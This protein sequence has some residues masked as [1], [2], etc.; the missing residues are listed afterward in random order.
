MSASRFPQDRVR[1]LSKTK[2]QCC[3]IRLRAERKA[4]QILAK[5]RKASGRPRKK[6]PRWGKYQ[7]RRPQKQAASLSGRLRT[8]KNSEPSPTSNSRPLSNQAEMPTTAGIIRA[9]AEPKQ[10]PV[11]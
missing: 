8:G 5:T 7:K 3:E 9:T 11:A 6:S 10:N 2:R 1:R 4:G